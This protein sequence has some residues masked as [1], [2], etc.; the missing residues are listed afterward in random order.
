MHGDWT[1]ED[2]TPSLVQRRVLR[3][4]NFFSILGVERLAITHGRPAF[5]SSETFETSTIYETLLLMNNLRA[6]VLTNCYNLAFVVALNPEKNAFRTVICPKL[7]ELFVYIKK[8][9]RFCIP[10][11]LEMAKARAIV[12]ARLET[13]TIVGSR[14]FVPLSEVLK[15]RACIRHVE[16][17]LDVMPKWDDIPGDAQRV[18]Y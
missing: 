7:Q 13:I 5:S 4:L 17:R 12:G 11:L 2:I 8:K 14:E 18:D 1:N 3:S 16:Y 15:L 6:L 10:E 9:E